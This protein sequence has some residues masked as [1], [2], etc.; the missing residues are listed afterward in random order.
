MGSWSD[1]TSV[2]AAEVSRWMKPALLLSK[3]D[4]QRVGT[5]F[6][7]VKTQTYNN[8]SLAFVWNLE[9][10]SPSR[11]EWK[12]VSKDFL[13]ATYFSK[14]LLFKLW[15]LNSAEISWDL[16]SLMQP[17]LSVPST[18]F[19]LR[20]PKCEVPSLCCLWQDPMFTNQLWNLDSQ[21]ALEHDCEGT[22]EKCKDHTFQ[23]Q[24]FPRVCLFSSL[25]ATKASPLL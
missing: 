18:K 21:L 9:C 6:K 20:K 17:R 3:I 7:N 12:G 15:N 25:D 8:M 4:C 5:H 22:T 24:L 14:H 10:A 16:T 23:L 1:R 2:L 19:S 13:C 11:R